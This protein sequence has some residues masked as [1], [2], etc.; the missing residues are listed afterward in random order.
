MD[1]FEFYEP[2][3]CLFMMPFSFLE[4]KAFPASEGYF[5]KHYIKA[6]KIG[7]TVLT[8]SVLVSFPFHCLK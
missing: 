4:K 3:E 1:S 2:S 5:F 6:S 7:L 8:L